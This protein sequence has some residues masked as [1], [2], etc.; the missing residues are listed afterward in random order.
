MKTKYLYSIVA[1]V[2]LIAEGCR[3]APSPVLSADPA[4]LRYTAKG[5]TKTY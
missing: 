2:I 4:S 3:T 1:V 5:G